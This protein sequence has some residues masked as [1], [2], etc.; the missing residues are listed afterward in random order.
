MSSSSER[1]P[2]AAWSDVEPRAELPVLFSALLGCEVE[3]VRFVRPA[4][5]ELKR[6]ILGG[7][8]GLGEPD[9]AMAVSLGR[10]LGGARSACCGNVLSEIRFVLG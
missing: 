6:G 5:A 2:E 10:E 1:V 8:M 9:D 4:K 7:A 3:D